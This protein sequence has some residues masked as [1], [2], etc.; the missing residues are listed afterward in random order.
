MVEGKPFNTEHKLNE[1]SHVK[2]IKQ[3]K[4]GLGPDR[5]M[6]TCKETEE[7]TK[8]GIIRKISQHK[9]GMS[10]RLLSTTRDR[11][12]NRVPHRV[13]FE[14]LPRRLQGLPSNPNGRRRR[15]QNSLLRRRMSLLLQEDA[16][17][18]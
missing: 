8:V 13:P 6:A 4:G 16:I 17:W 11:L 14:V 9:Q 12:E 7:L 2:L 10:Q 1:Y 15:R 3:N 5:N 18:S